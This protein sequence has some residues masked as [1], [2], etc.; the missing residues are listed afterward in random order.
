MQLQRR[1][2]GPGEDEKR[3]GGGNELL[4]SEDHRTRAVQAQVKPVFWVWLE[5]I[6]VDVTMTRRD[7]K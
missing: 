3:R 2:S 6:L 4:R 7:I 5:E 1:K